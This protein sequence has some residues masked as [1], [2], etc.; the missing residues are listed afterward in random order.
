M[1]GP[2]N[3]DVYEKMLADKERQNKELR[4]HVKEL[5]EALEAMLYD[6]TPIDGYPS[7]SAVDRARAA[8]AKAGGG[9]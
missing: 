3:L 2:S 9:G 8:L 4:A 5:R 7:E 6:L 1:T